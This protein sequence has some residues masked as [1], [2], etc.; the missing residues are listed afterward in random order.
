[1]VHPNVLQ[2]EFFTS[3]IDAR[4]R[5]QFTHARIRCQAKRGSYL[6]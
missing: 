6:Q 5:C 3:R 2:G 1:L 4:F